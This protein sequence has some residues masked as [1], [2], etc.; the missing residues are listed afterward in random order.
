M[1]TMTEGTYRNHPSCRVLFIAAAGRS[2]STVLATLLGTVDGLCSVGELRF[3]WQRGI[4]E[5]RLCG[6]GVPFRECDFWQAVMTEAFGGIENIDVERILRAQDSSIRVRHVPRRL[7]ESR[8]GIDHKYDPVYL[9]ALTQVY[10]AIH[11]VTSG[12]IIVDTSKPPIYMDALRRLPHMDVAVV[13]LVRDP[14]GNAYSWSR[15]KRR[16]SAEGTAFMEQHSALKASLLWSLWN[17]TSRAI[18]I[19]ESARRYIQVRYEDLVADPPGES[20]RVLGMVQRSSRDVPFITPNLVSTG[21]NHMVA[22]NPDR[23]NRGQLELRA[24]QR[25]QQEM[26]RRQ[27][28]VASVVAAPVMH[29]FGYSLRN[30]KAGNGG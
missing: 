29:S 17:V 10:S 26:T 24:D 5:N 21:V 28:L 3:L 9:S 6:C 14:R 27:R 30:H 25:W 20:D 15:L 12:A 23:L 22:G 2:G 8:V 4:I 11:R 1:T 19:G 16:D 18:W 7:V 13:H